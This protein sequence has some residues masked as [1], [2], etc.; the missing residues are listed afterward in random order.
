V[1]EFKEIL[2]LAKIVVDTLLEK[3]LFITTV[4]SCTGGG[5]ANYIT[6]ISGASD[7]IK[8]AAVTYSNDEKISFGVSET[9]I[10]QFDVYSEETAIAMAKAGIL[11]SV[12]AEVGV[13][14]TGSFTRVDENNTGSE[15]GVIY[16]AVIYGDRVLSKKV[17]LAGKDE[18][19]VDKDKVIVDAFNMVLEIIE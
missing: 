10:K 7:V 17:C 16:I 12:R 19:W 9:L 11:K 5:M 2:K 18:R 14:I 6:N 8:G 1:S 3:K 13:G 4:E 15:V